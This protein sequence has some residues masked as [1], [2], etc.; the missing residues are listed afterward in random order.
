MQN[1][2]VISD[3]HVSDDA[4][5]DSGPSL[6][7]INPKSG[8][9]GDTMFRELVNC[10]KAEGI[11]IDW[12]VCPGDLGDRANQAGQKYAWENLD[13]LKGELGC[14]FL[15]GTAGNHDLDSRLATNEF[16]P[17]ANLQSLLP[18]F[19]GITQED[20][21]KYW[22][23]HFCFYVNDGV[24]V[25]NLNSSAYHGYASSA[26]EPEHLHG[27][28][29]PRTIDEICAEL[30]GVDADVNI[31]LTHHHLLKNDHIYDR[32]NS[33][34]SGAGRLLNK[35]T[36]ATKR[37]WIVLHGHQHFPEIDYGRGAGNAPIV[38]SAGSFS[39]RLSGVHA[40]ASPNQ[41]YVVELDK[42]DPLQDGWFPCGKIKAWH[43]SPEGF[44]E[45][46]P[47]AHRIPYGAGFGCRMNPWQSSRRVIGA[48]SE[49]T[50]PYLTLQEILNLEPLLGYMMPRDFGLLIWE[51][52]RSGVKV[53]KAFDFMETT[54][55]KLAVS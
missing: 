5:V 13:R 34:M 4:T 22:A 20:C 1:F 31:L 30:K 7:S 28:V 52:E 17:K 26:G 8:K 48:L 24:R 46:T 44:W 35:L 3:L 49:S 42:P 18:L 6:I 50:Q 2:L 15:I 32:D 55:R 11:S 10:V 45:K 37:P 43:W 53:T 38:I 29:S 23:R 16:D 39:A 51:L 25:L 21:D 14:K 9:L 54:F 19:P 12:I 33:E 27:R 36:D 47:M 41:F 40:A